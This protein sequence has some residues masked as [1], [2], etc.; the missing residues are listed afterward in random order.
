MTGPSTAKRDDDAQDWSVG[1]AADDDLGFPP[2]ALDT[3]DASDFDDA[4]FDDPAF[5]TPAFDAPAF[6]GAA[7]P[8]DP[9]DAPIGP[10]LSEAPPI[11]DRYVAANGP[12][13]G[14][15]HPV[16]RITIAAFCDRPEIASL[17]MSI[18]KDRRLAKATMTVETGGVTTGIARLTTQASPNLLILDLGGSP[19]ALL[20]DLDRIAEYVDAGT[21]ALVI[22]AANDIGLYRELM[23][24]GVSEYLVPPIQPVDVIRAISTLYADP[25]K[26]FVGRV[27]AILGAR[28]GSGSST[29]AQNVA[30]TL[31]ERF[32]AATTLIDL[33]VCFG[34]AGLNF[35]EDAE[36]GV[37]EVLQKADQID[38]TY[39]ERLLVR[40]SEHLSLFPASAALERDLEAGPQAYE[41]LIEQV[42]RIAPF[43]V[44]DLPHVW[45]R[46][47]RNT[48]LAADDVVIVATPDLAALRN[49]K[50]LFDVIRSNRPHDSPPAM[51]LNM[52]G[53]PKRP[54][55]PV[56][57][58]A[59]AL[60]V[61]PI[62]VVPF[63]PAVFGAASNA[64]QM[65][66]AASPESKPAVALETVAR[67]LCG[68]EPVARR[69]TSLLTRLL[70]R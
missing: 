9:L 31:A 50:N 60:G 21:K 69:Q 58:F 25:D 18:G 44:L 4:G 2:E 22:G 24:R 64:G 70:K 6:S 48:V 57:E 28:G 5:S 56:R 53:V 13:I 41:T 45:S 32:H 12:D 55:I 3:F 43:V 51:V 14:A 52:V 42:R 20:A 15:E 35:D 34:T 19:T 7:L 61:E 49:A 46:W 47:M 39:L 40:R 17:L 27:A 16:P 29:V 63:E 11:V 1:P 23:K 67:A 30:W 66:I 26:P 65:V 38:Q 54:E 36:M 62:A 68:R 33:D 37:G 59:K 10:S 8:D